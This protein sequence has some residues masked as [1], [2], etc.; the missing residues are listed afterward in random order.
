MTFLL[1]PCKIEKFFNLIQLSLMSG[2]N[3]Q[4]RL[5]LQNCKL[6]LN[7]LRDN[8]YFNKILLSGKPEISIIIMKINF[9]LLVRVLCLYRLKHNA[10]YEHKA[11]ERNKVRQITTT[12]PTPKISKLVSYILLRIIY[13]WSQLLYKL[14]HFPVNHLLYKSKNRLLFNYT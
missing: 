7:F 10:Y 11:I 8:F 5:Y 9:Y 12:Y 2:Q 13:S 3:I 6:S 4:S 14:L 1:R